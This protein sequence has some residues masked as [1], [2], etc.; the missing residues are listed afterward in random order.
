MKVHRQA[1]ETKGR[2]GETNP[3]PASNPDGGTTISS[4]NETPTSGQYCPPGQELVNNSEDKFYCAAQEWCSVTQGCP[5][6]S[7]EPPRPSEE[8]RD[9]CSALTLGGP[10]VI[11]SCIIMENIYKIADWLTELMP[12][13]PR[14]ISRSIH[15]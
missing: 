4:P 13:F 12:G 15:F 7:L 2:P 14:S 8:A 10:E 3:E 5:K 6:E 11:S 9:K 1:G